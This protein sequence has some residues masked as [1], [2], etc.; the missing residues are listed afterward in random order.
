M[1]WLTSTHANNLR[2]TIIV[3]LFLSLFSLNAFSQTEDTGDLSD[4]T[5]QKAKDTTLIKLGSLDI[6]IIDHEG[7]LD[8]DN[9]F[10]EDRNIDHKRK[11]FISHWQGLDI[12]VNGYLTSKGSI[13][14][15]E[16]YD[17]LDLNYGKS[18]SFGLNL[19]EKNIKLHGNNITIVTGFGID[20]NNYSFENNTTLIA[21]NDTVS[22]YTDSVV[23]FTRNKLKMVSVKVPILLGLSMGREFSRSFHLATGVVLAYKF[24]SKTKQ[25]YHIGNDKYKPKVKSNFNLL[26]FRYSAALRIGYGRFSLFANYALSPLF[27]TN[28]GPELYPFEV[29]FNLMVH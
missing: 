28:A 10:R 11:V 25:K 3:L 24:E 1:Y 16:A 14:M 5:E 12:G 26:P 21:S 13:S 4:T 7:I 19:L 22:A 15:D 23:S 8:D 27:D 17:F 6:L 29:G 20:F 18:F 2:S 9:D